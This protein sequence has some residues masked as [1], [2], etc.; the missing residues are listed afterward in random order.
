MDKI[1]YILYL[2][3]N[4]L[5]FFF[6]ENFQFIILWKC[7][8]IIF[9]IKTKNI[10]LIVYHFVGIFLYYVC[11]Q[12]EFLL[13]DFSFLFYILY[14]YFSSVYTKVLFY[15]TWIFLRIFWFLYLI[16]ISN[17]SQIILGYYI[18]F[19]IGIIWTLQLLRIYN[20]KNNYN[21]LVLLLPIFIFKFMYLKNFLLLNFFIIIQFLHD[22]SNLHSM[23]SFI[24]TL[25]YLKQIHINFFCCMLLF[26]F[27]YIKNNYCLLYLLYFLNI[28]IIIITNHLSIYL[29]PFLLISYLL[30]K[31]YYSHFFWYLFNSIYLCFVLLE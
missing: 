13:V 25:F 5:L 9:S 27:I 15:T 11:Q 29:L 17:S 22:N 24:N 7:I 19:Y 30:K 26:I 31:I 2:I 18:L 14:K 6:Y 20:F 21:S 4:I 12:N 10:L 16:F 8:D 1:R 23:C 28:L 3:F